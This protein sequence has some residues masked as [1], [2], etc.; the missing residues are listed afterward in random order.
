MHNS[1]YNTSI[2]DQKS[3]ET[4]LERARRVMREF[5]PAPLLVDPTKIDDCKKI[6]VKR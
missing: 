4:G 1:K 6:D 3:L 2:E 5:V